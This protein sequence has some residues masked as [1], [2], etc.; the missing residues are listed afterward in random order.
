MNK[1]VILSKTKLSGDLYV[2]SFIFRTMYRFGK[3]IWYNRGFQ[4]QN[5]TVLKL[6]QQLV[7]KE[8]KKKIFYFEDK[9]WTVA[10]VSKNNKIENKTTE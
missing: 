9:T 8:P 5:T 3:L 10:D 1:Q 2:H 6:F 7:A 4:K